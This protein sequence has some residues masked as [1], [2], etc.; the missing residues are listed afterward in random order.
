MAGLCE[1]GNELSGSLKPVSKM[2]PCI[3]GSYH[4]GM[5]RP[6]VVDRGDGLQIWSVAVNILNKQSRTADEGVLQL[7]DWAKG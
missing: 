3:V 1:G 7:G 2:E 4:H 6:Q 5:A